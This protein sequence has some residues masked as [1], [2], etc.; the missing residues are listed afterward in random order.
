MKL[1][2]WSHKNGFR[3]PTEQQLARW[4]TDGGNYTDVQDAVL[5]DGRLYSCKAELNKARLVAKLKSVMGYV[6]SKLQVKPET[7]STGRLART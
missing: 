2:F 5:C 7:A 6:Q 1:K 3:S 4:E